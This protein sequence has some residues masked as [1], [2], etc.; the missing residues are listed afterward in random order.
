M[1]SRRKCSHKH[2]FQIHCTRLAEP[3]LVALSLACA[4]K[5]GDGYATFGHLFAC[6]QSSGIDED[7]DSMLPCI[8][9]SAQLRKA[10][11]RVYGVRNTC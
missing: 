3:F 10:L 5:D 1:H 11:P 4:V 7:D 6:A 9:P 8:L 2:D